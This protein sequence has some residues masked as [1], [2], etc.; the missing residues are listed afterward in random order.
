MKNNVVRLGIIGCG[1]RGRGCAG[2]IATFPD[3]EIV[4]LYDPDTPCLEKAVEVVKER[5]GGKVPKAVSDYHEMLKDPEIDAI[6][7]FASWETHI[8]IAI[9]CMKAGK[10]SAMEVGGA[11]SI[12]AC[13]EL[14]RTYEATGIPC[15]MLENC[16]YGK[17]ELMVANMVR[18]G[19]FGRIVHCEGGYRHD[20]RKEIVGGYDRRHYRLFNYLTRCAENYPTHEIGPIAK[21]LNINRGNRMVSLVSMA[22]LSF[23]MEEYVEKTTPEDSPLRGKD[24]A[25]GDVVTTVIRCAGGETITLTLDTSLPR[26]YSRDFTVQ[27]TKGMYSEE[28]DSIFFDDGTCNHGAAIYKQCGNAVNHE[29]RFLSPKWRPENADKVIGGHGGMDGFVFGDFIDHVRR[30]DAEMPIDVYDAAA[31]MAI[32][33]LSEE[34]ILKG[35]APVAFP[36]FTNGAWVYRKPIDCDD[37]S[38]P[39]PEPK[40][41]EPKAE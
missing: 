27:G 21:I 19:I 3:V 18:H 24:F 8:P 6:M 20:L 34:S 39:I 23:G 7:N 37:F 30:G 13:Y 40:A 5:S 15:M 25:Q 10:W 38:A 26:F 29:D 16:C 31:W 17:R 9:E 12:E 32:T 14:V 2:L 36:D 33:A 4:S 35:G 1:N 41:E 28:S 11:Y 22:S